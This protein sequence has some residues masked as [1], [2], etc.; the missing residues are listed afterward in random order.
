MYHKKG[1]E[2][3]HSASLHTEGKVRF[4]GPWFALEFCSWVGL[5]GRAWEG[6]YA[7]EDLQ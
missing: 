7:D 6:V 5:W 2:G 3:T 1:S 4:Q